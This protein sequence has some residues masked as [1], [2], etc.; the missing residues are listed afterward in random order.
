MSDG[1]IFLIIFTVIFVVRIVF[2]TMFFHAVLPDSDRCPE[3][4]TPTLRVHSRGWNL[5][6]PWFRTSW[7]YACGWRGLLR[8]GHLTAALA[9]LPSK[10]RSHRR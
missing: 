9:T 7:C 6:M 2:A 3:C 8:H 1:W 5:L 4:D 10:V